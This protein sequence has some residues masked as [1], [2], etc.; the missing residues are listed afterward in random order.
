[1]EGLARLIAFFVLRR[2]VRGYVQRRYESSF[3][4]ELDTLELRL[5]Q[6]EAGIYTPQDSYVLGTVIQNRLEEFQRNNPKKTNPRISR[7]IAK[8]DSV[9]QNTL[10]RLD[11]ESQKQSQAKSKALS[12]LPDLQLLSQIRDKDTVKQE[13]SKGRR[14]RGFGIFLIFAAF[15]SFCGLFGLFAS[16]DETVSED[17]SGNVALATF[18][19]PPLIL[20]PAIIVFFRGN[21]RASNLA[22][23]LSIQNE[24]DTKRDFLQEIY[25]R[26]TSRYAQ[27]YEDYRWEL[28]SLLQRTKNEDLQRLFQ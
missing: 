25:G 4:A 3:T 28:A 6:I 20:I 23:E 22:E 26:D 7:I 14:T 21:N 12:Y 5:P 10:S 17:L 13:L 2:T 19:I 11:S 18:C 27:L 8:L 15:L 16:F 9:K 24:L 1:M